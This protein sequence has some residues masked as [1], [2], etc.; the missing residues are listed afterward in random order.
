[1]LE[2]ALC[3]QANHLDRK[4]KP[5]KFVAKE[6][7]EVISPQHKV[8]EPVVGEQ[9]MAFLKKNNILRSLEKGR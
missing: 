1:M 5:G 9:E 2:D 8:L 4:T 3:L 7:K 6:K